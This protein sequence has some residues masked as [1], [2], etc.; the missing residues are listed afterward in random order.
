MSQGS[1]F[2]PR[3]SIALRVFIAPLCPAS[4][5]LPPRFTRVVGSF[6]FA[7]GWCV[8]PAAAQQPPLP[9]ELPPPAGKASTAPSVINTQ[10]STAPVQIPGWS[11]SLQAG[12]E[13]Y[14]RENAKR[15]QATSAQLGWINE[16]RRRAALPPWQ[17]YYEGPAYQGVIAPG[18]P[19]YSSGPA[20]GNAGDPAG[21]SLWTDPASAQT[22][23]GAFAAPSG[24]LADSILQEPWLPYSN[25]DLFGY[26]YDNPVRHPVGMESIHRADGS[27]ES[28]PVYADEFSPAHV[29]PLTIAPQ[30]IVEPPVVLETPPVGGPVIETLPPVEN[31][32]LTER[33]VDA[34]AVRG[35][36]IS[37]LQDGDFARTLELSSQLI[38][39]QPN[40]A[41]ALLLSLHADLGLGQFTD[42]VAD[43]DLACKR[44]PAADWDLVARDYRAYFGTAGNFTRQLRG[45]EA[46]VR[47]L[48]QDAE[49]RLMLGYLYSALGHPAEAADQLREA[50]RLS[51]ADSSTAKLAGRLLDRFGGRGV[52]QPAAAS[53]PVRKGRIF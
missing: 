16:M 22:S 17:A 53:E 28:R 33:A 47:D 7:L 27:Y 19:T 35:Q 50:Q 24:S 4:R 43:L 29:V 41:E 38:A 34:A 3:S 25:V 49:A 15:L 20:Y 32:P 46:A 6:L 1:S 40:S 42:A 5:Q 13:A 18:G 48:P 9:Q 30:T 51:A 26:R 52:P 11:D 39:A 37:A 31:I 10:A 44:L 2:A 45:V 23:Y 36:A 12:Y 21:L 14:Q 8:T